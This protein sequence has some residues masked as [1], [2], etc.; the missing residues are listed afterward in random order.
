MSDQE[1]ALAHNK[2]ARPL[3]VALTRINMPAKTGRLRL[4]NFILNWLRDNLA[5]PEHRPRRAQLLIALVIIFSVAFAVRL[6]RFQDGQGE[7]NRKGALLKDLITPYWK[8]AERIL[9]DGRLLFPLEYPDAGDARMVVHPPG[10]PIV[11]AATFK[12]SGDYD[13]LLSATQ[14]VQIICDSVAAALLFMIAAELLPFGVAIIAGLLVALSPHLSYYSLWLS[15]DSLAALPVLIAVHLM[16]R[17]TKRPRIVTAISAG[18]MIGLSCWLRSNALLLAPFLAAIV[19]LVVERSKR[20]KFSMAVIAAT[21]IVISPITV[22][23]RAVYHRFIPL[24]V[25]AGITLVEGIADYDKEGRFGMPAVDDD[26]KG[27]DAEWFGRPEYQG[28]IWEPDG[29]D[30]DRGRFARGLEVVRSNPA[31][32]AGVMIRRAAF[33]LRYNDSRPY[34]WPFSSAKVDLVSAEPPFGHWHVNAEGRDVVWSKSPNDA[35]AGGTVLS[36]NAAVSLGEAPPVITIAGDGSQFGDQFA[37]E[38]VAVEKFTDY[39][40]TFPAEH[41]QGRAAAKVTTSDRRITLASALIADQSGETERISKKR[42]KKTQAE[43]GATDSTDLI[44]GEPVAMIEIP[45]ASGDRT[46]V[47]LVISNDG[48]IEARPIVQIGEVSLMKMGP[49]P[50]TELR[51]VR[52]VARGLQRNLFTTSLMLPLVIMGI[53]LLALAGRNGALLILLAVP[54][55]YLMIQSAFHTEY[56][57]ILAIHYF[58]FVMAAVTFYCAALLVKQGVRRIMASVNPRSNLSD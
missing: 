1:S 25:G 53:C 33:M 27:K 34:E 5:P 23:N 28:S 38:A 22:R 36:R 29:I 15:P 18:A 7:I 46:E 55:Y 4:T 11:L 39:V 35:I 21:I 30:R 14:F 3:H 10:Y 20:W 54:A 40:L 24:S 6:L 41:R 49:T 43:G 50:Q 57:Y 12:A 58:L 31:W 13:S 17:A 45:F 19:L 44:D 37:F 32:F 16:V 8:E 56:R 26:V 2:P 47:R 48:A 42:M 51:L 52:G 9:Q